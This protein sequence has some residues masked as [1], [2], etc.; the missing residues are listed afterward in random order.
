MKVYIII[1]TYTEE[2]SGYIPVWGKS[3]TNKEEAEQSAKDLT[4]LSKLTGKNNRFIVHEETV[5]N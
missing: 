1:N 5:A 4:D 2:N 3:T